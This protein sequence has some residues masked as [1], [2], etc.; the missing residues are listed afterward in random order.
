MTF[1]APLFAVI[2]LAGF[3]S[4]AAAHCQ[5]P[6][7]I[8]GDQR[9]FDEMLED[10]ETITKAIDQIGELSGTHDATG[11]NQLARWV[12]TKEDHATNVQR[13]IGDYF[14]AQRIKSDDST[15]GKKLMA[16]HKVMVDAMKAKQAADPATAKAL[17]KSIKDFYE[18]YEGKA[19]EAAHTH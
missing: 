11:H 13:I 5:V 3:A 14:M 6:C 18:A 15:Y 12:V 16:A 2:A 7:G 19:Y 8:Y 4:Q 1:R 17:E 10:T 9:R